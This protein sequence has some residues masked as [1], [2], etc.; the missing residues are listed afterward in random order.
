MA[1]APLLNTDLRIIPLEEAD[2]AGLDALFDEQCAEWLSLLGWDYSGPSRLIREVVRQRELSGFVAVSGGDIIGLS[3]YIIEPARCSIGDI[4]VSKAWRE[5]G[6]DA[7]MVA[8][9]LDRIDLLPRA[10][11]VESQCVTVASEGA[12]AVF[13]SRG[14]VRLDRDYM[15]CKL[16]GSGLHEANDRAARLDEKSASIF[17]RAW[18]GRDFS[19]AARVIRA[20]YR[21]QPDSRINSQYTSEEGCAELLS[22]LTDRVWCGDFLPQVSRVATR[23]HSGAMAG[24][25]I[26]SRLAPGAGHIGQISVHPAWQNLGIGRRMISEA[27]DLFGNR[28]FNSVSLAVTT[29]NSAAL[30]L[31]RSCGFRTVHTFPVFYRERP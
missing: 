11:R 19:G 28:G 24:V 29:S 25:L 15:M 17:T 21:D 9:I 13:E 23:R 8:A 5:C 3:Y 1:T 2:S 26:A 18:E 20:S 6:A 22:I 14:F 10:R 12:S 30:H 31:Y 4:Y 16:G 7:M 27:L